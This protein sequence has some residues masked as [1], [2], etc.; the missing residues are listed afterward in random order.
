MRRKTLSEK[1]PDK[2]EPLEIID[3]IDPIIHSP[4]RLKIL[5]V[6]S[7]VMKADFTFLVLTT[8]LTRGNLSANL[9]KLEEAGYISIEKGFIKRVSRTMIQLTDQ[10]RNAIMSYNEDMH[11]I[12]NTL[13]NELDS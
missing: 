1:T 6:L 12:L 5:V 7:E 13:L 9:R 3:E 8:G 11:I 2:K 4:T 10:G